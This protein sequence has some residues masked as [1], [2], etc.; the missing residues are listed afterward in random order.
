MNLSYYLKWLAPEILTA[1]GM[2]SA[3]I[4]FFALAGWPYGL[5]FGGACLL[6]V[7]LFIENN[8]G[9]VQE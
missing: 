1:I 5:I 8:L 4:G 3:T 2:L 7:A 6:V 9:R